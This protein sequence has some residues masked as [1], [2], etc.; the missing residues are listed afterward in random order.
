MTLHFNNLDPHDP[1]NLGRVEPQPSS[2]NLYRSFGKRLL[3]I[4]LVGCSLPFVLPVILIMAALVA[5]DGHNPFYFQLRVGKNG[6]HFSIFKIR[7][8]VPNAEE[9]LKEYLARNLEARQEWRINQKLRNDP[10]ITPI[11]KF[12]RNSSLD[13]LPQ[14]L[15]VLKGDMS[16]IG[17]RPMMLAQ[18]TLYPGQAYYHLRPGISGSWQVSDRN[19]TSFAARATYDNDYHQKVSLWGDIKI[20]A[21]TVVVVLRR[22]GC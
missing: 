17:P 20:I 4:L 3:D 10:R 6:R 14:L 18:A 8:M 22:T 12:L 19:A 11:G 2:S 1:T 16:L 5:L 13:E 9:H 7:T 15:N 21:R